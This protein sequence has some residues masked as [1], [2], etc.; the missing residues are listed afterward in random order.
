MIKIV[1]GSCSTNGFDIKQFYT[2]F[3][4]EKNAAFSM[5]AIA[6][7][8]EEAHDAEEMLYDL[9]GGTYH[10]SPPSSRTN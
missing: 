5:V 6:S 7:T 10:I 2:V 9:R 4:V 8:A 1:L 3:R